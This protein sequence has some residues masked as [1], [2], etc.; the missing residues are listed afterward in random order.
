MPW[1]F[2]KENLFTG[3]HIGSRSHVIEREQNTISGD[4]EERQEFVNLEEEEAEEFN[5]EFEQK[6][7]EGFH[8]QLMNRRH[9]GGL[10][11]ITSG[12]NNTAAV[13]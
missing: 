13:G 4:Q 8:G 7:R 3:H 1:N 2:F 11:P 10:T 5:R 9:T 12:N 6:A